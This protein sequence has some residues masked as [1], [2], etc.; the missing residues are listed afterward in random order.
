MSCN[1]QQKME[2]MR[3]VL[4]V[5]IPAEIWTAN[6]QIF[7]WIWTPRGKLQ[8]TILIVEVSTNITCN[9]IQI[10]CEQRNL[11][12]V[13]SVECDFTKVSHPCKSVAHL[14][15]WILNI[16][17]YLFHTVV[18]QQLKQLF[19]SNKVLVIDDMS[20]WYDAHMKIISASQGGF[21]VK[22]KHEVL[23][24]ESSKFSLW[25]EILHKPLS[26]SDQLGQPLLDIIV[27]VIML[28]ASNN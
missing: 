14:E 15:S 22:L 7:C 24:R 18:S 6:T 4:E 27:T 12:G 28:H 19:K 16:Y 3:D 17:I 23:T 10:Y 25:S 13:S 5:L 20:I 11:R 1:T 8:N 2:A 9:R 21:R 26:S